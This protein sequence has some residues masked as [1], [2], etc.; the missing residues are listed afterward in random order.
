MGF[1]VGDSMVVITVAGM[2]FCPKERKKV[3][4][5]NST[6]VRLEPLA[7][8][9]LYQLGARIGRQWVVLRPSCAHARFMP[10][11]RS[12]STQI[13]R[14]GR[15]VPA[16]SSHRKASTKLMRPGVLRKSPALR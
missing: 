4:T 11:G 7:R 6:K 5:T 15:P 12:G 9:G 14:S 16:A 3:P 2:D 1:F 8:K 10:V 13:R